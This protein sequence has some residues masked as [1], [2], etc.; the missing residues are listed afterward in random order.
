MI[1][2]LRTYHAIPGKLPDLQRLLQTVI[3]TV[4]QEYGITQIGVWIA[5]S[6]RDDNTIR[7]MLRW[8]SL[9]DRETRW[10]R[11]EHDRFFIAAQ[12]EAESMISN[13]ENTFLTPTE[14][15]KLQ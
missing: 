9:A 11:L 7:C 13:I 4:Y 8:Q 14:Y 10:S 1:F 5:D 15:S 2:E 12:K 3:N 6:E